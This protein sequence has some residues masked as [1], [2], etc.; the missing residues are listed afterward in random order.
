MKGVEYMKINNLEELL[1]V[2]NESKMKLVVVASHDE[3][4]LKAVSDSRKLGIAEPVLIG[5][6]D[7]TL[8]LI[9]EYD[10]G[11]SDCEIIDEP[12]PVKAAEIGVKLISSNKANFIM[13]G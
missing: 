6:R 7:K 8:K 9:D 2:K 12:D 4:V 13:K 1:K 3:E 11:L 5:D 10:L